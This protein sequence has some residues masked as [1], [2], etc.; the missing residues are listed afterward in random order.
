MT[1]GTTPTLEFRLPFHSSVI[2]AA[3]VTFD[4][5]GE[6]VLEKDLAACACEEDRLILKLTQEDTL[7]FAEDQVV[8]IQIRVRT[9][10]GNAIASNIMTTPAN[11]ILKDGVI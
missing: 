1:R 8:E 5:N 7:A 9:V 10:D 2:Q 6:T 4:Q 11:R 3:Y